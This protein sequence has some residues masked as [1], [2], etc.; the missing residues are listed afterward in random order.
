MWGSSQARTILS[1]QIRD[2]PLAAAPSA[3]SALVPVTM[4]AHTTSEGQQAH[5]QH[6]LTKLS[7]AAPAATTAHDGEGP[8]GQHHLLRHVLSAQQCSDALRHFGTT[9]SKAAARMVNRMSQRELRDMFAKVYTVTTNSNNNTWL[10]RKLLEAVGASRRFYNASNR[11]GRPKA[12]RRSP[13]S[14]SGGAT[15]KPRKQQAVPAMP[16]TPT[17]SPTALHH[18]A[19]AVGPAL[20]AGSPRALMQRMRSTAAASGSTT[21]LNDAH[22][23]SP[24]H[25]HHQLQHAFLPTPR[26]QRYTSQRAQSSEEEGGASSNRSSGDDTHPRALRPAGAVLD[27][28]SPTCA[29]AFGAASGVAV[30]EPVQHY[31]Q[32]HYQQHYQQLAS[33]ARLPAVL[34]SFSYGSVSSSQF[35]VPPLSM[36]APNSVPLS[37]A[38]LYSTARVAPAGWDGLLPPVPSLA[39]LSALLGGYPAPDPQP[40]HQPEPR[41]QLQA[42]A[43]PA[44]SAN[45]HGALSADLNL[46]LFGLEAANE[47]MPAAVSPKQPASGEEWLTWEDWKLPALI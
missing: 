45:L 12:S 25:A 8:N 42:A 30:A 34:D 43:P 46:G 28:A 40:Q 14:S 6:Q 26:F 24:R 21:A 37:L 16:T 39:A 2:T 23:A 29:S 44:C 31:Y 27:C 4:S 17:A 22:A 3:A 15:P 1:E 32:Q 7:Q 33:G 20:P 36:P 13:A 19:F 38:P 41:P 9:D 5:T 35:S 18:P 10:R 47:P 11:T